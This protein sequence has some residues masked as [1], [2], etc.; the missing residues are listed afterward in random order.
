MSHLVVSQEQRT[1]MLYYYSHQ[2]RR[3]LMYS[4]SL[5]INDDNQGRAALNLN[6][7]IHNLSLRRHTACHP[8]VEVLWNVAGLCQ[9]I[10]RAH[11]WKLPMVGRQARSRRSPTVSAHSTFSGY[12]A[13]L[14]VCVIR[15]VNLVHV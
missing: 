3:L 11:T 12:T 10:G 5:T 2:R 15:G 9:Q 7:H 1:K 4:V 14:V 13:V 6:C 8:L